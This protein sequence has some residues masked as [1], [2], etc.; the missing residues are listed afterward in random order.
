MPARLKANE[1]RFNIRICIFTRV[2]TSRRHDLKLQ[3]EMRGRACVR[4]HAR[5]RMRARTV[6]RTRKFRYY[7]MR[8]TFSI[9][10]V[11]SK[12]R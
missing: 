5:P 9:L 12:S 7:C 6:L 2:E 1:P 8:E 3:E 4:V 11:E 10:G